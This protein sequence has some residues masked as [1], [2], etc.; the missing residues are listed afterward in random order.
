VIIH[1]I[2]RLKRND[3]V[4]AV[5]EEVL[6]AIVMRER[7]RSGVPLG[8]GAY[9]TL[10]APGGPLAQAAPPQDLRR[11]PPPSSS[12]PTPGRPTSPQPGPSGTQGGRHNTAGPPTGPSGARGGPRH[13]PPGF[14]TVDLTA[15]AE[16]EKEEEM[17]A[18][19]AMP[20]PN[21]SDD[22][23]NDM[24]TDE[25]EDLL[26]YHGLN[27]DSSSDEDGFQHV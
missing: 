14:A 10:A 5:E 21:V 4:R 7:G 19:P 16:E 12:A 3:L 11:R 9:A 17:D 22:S 26:A 18:T 15:D 1:R 24:K 13:P 2:Q 20:P 8:D 23:S 25:E 6:V 27:R